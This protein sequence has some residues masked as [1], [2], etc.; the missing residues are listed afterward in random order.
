MAN[1]TTAAL[2]KEQFTE[3]I[4][5]IQQGF[6]GSLPN[7]RIATALVLEANLGLRI[8]DILN[9]HLNDIIHDGERYRLNIKE[10]KTGKVRSFTVPNEVY[11]YIKIYTLENGI[12]ADELIFPIKKR[13]VQKTLKKASDYL[14]IPNIGTHS[15]RKFFATEIFV[16]NGYNIILVQI[17]LQHSSPATSQHYIGMSAKDIEDALQKHIHLL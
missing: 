8:S 5:M 15:F 9:L 11:Q 3:L 16:N 2:T 13:V 10:I 1:K 12:R 7:R 17:L 14:G 4:E 6:V